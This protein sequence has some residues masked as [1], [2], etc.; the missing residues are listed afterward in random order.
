M[1]GLYH[2]RWQKQVG[3]LCHSSRGVGYR[4]LTLQACILG[5]IAEGLM[6]TNCRA[7]VSLSLSL[8]DLNSNGT[9][10]LVP[11]ILLCLICG[12]HFVYYLDFF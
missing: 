3:N 9:T 8:Y 11:F 10:L 2:S 6:P 12:D 7:Y 5:G 4:D 1:L